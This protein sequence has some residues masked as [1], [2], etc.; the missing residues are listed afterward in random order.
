MLTK[1]MIVEDEK[2]VREELR[3][4]LTSAAYEV[5]AAED[6][7]NIASQIESEKP[8]LVLL[9]VKLPGTNGHEI[10]KEVRRT[11]DV[12]IIFVTS[13]DSVSSEIAGM[14]AGGDDYI[15]KPYHPA[16]LLAR[17]TAVLKRSR[18]KTEEY[19][20]THNG[21]TLDIR[22]YK[23][24][25]GERQAE[26]TKNEC[27]LLHYLFRRKG[28]VVP[29]MELIDYLWDNEVFID[30]NALSITVTRLRGKLEDIGIF[31]FIET[32]RG[33]GYRI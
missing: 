10:C 11:A 25:H 31:G 14:L 7:G 18:K 32:K 24:I 20:F 6:F 12:P 30:D 2:N 23:L 16:L 3:L 28:E 21:V 22:T 8:D 26:L 33:A 5:C 9:D 17:I 1:I 13:D 29:R 27:K 4:L 19:S 15:A